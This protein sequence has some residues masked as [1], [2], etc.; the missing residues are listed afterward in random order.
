M[1][2]KLL[3]HIGVAAVLG[4]A[5]LGVV[6]PEQQANAA[7]QTVTNCADSGTGSL[8]VAVADA[9]SGDTITFALSPACRVI[10]LTSGDIEINKNLTINGPGASSPTPSRRGSTARPFPRDHPNPQ[11]DSAPQQARACEAEPGW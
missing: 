4:L 2:R 6:I 9:N 5:V 7:T 10:T 8:R 11:A 1:R 3:R